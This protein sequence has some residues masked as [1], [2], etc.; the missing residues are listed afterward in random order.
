MVQGYIIFPSIIDI[1]ERLANSI[2]V[3]KD[4]TIIVDF[5][6]KGIETAQIF[7]IGVSMVS[8][9]W[10]FSEYNSVR[11][12]MLLDVTVS[13]CS[14][15]VMFMYMLFQ[16]IARL[17]AFMLFTLFWG[18]GN[19]YPLMIFITIH[20]ILAS[21]LHV[22]F[23]EDITYWHK[24]HYLKFFHNVIMNSFASIY[25]HNYLRFD[26]MPIV[27]R[28]DKKSLEFVDS[29]RPGLHIST[30]L[31]QLS[32]D[33]L[34]LVEFIIMLSFGFN[35]SVEDLVN[36][37][38]VFISVVFT[39]STLAFILRLTY[40]NILHV[41]NNVIL[42]GKKLIRQ[43]IITGDESNIQNRFFK[44]VFISRNTWILGSL[45]HIETTL[46]VLPT[47]IIDALKGRGKD[48]EENFTDVTR[49][50]RPQSIREFATL[51]SPNKLII[52]LLFFPM[53]VLVIAINMIIIALLLIGL[54]L[55]IPIALLVFLYNLKSGFRAVE[56]SDEEEGINTLELPPEI[57]RGEQTIFHSDSNLTLA[58][59]Q[60]SLVEENGI[61]N[62]SKLTDA[63]ADEFEVFAMLLLC[64]NRKKYPLKRLILDN[65]DLTDEK[66]YKLVPLIV[67][68]EKVCLNGSQKMTTD[69]WDCLL[70]ALNNSTFKLRVLEMKI[71]K[72]DDD[73]IRFRREIFLEE[74]KGSSMT[75]ES[76][77]KIALFIPKL[78]K[79]YMDDLF[80]DSMILDLIKNRSADEILEA[81]KKLASEILSEAHNRRLKLLSLQGCSI[82]DDVMNVIASAL[83]RI[84]KV[85][86]G[87]NNI[88][89]LGWQ[90][91]SNAWIDA[92]TTKDTSLTHLSL[93]IRNVQQHFNGKYL[94]DR[95]LEHLNKIILDL[96]DVDLTGQTEITTDGWNSLFK[97]LRSRVETIKKGS[98]TS[99]VESGEEVVKFNYKL[100]SINLTNCK[101]KPETKE[102]ID[103]TIKELSLDIKVHFGENITSSKFSNCFTWC[104]K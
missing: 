1:I 80:N 51:L 33:I 96:E 29:Q 27:Q 17:I 99:L 22:F 79:V 46:L 103:T 90:T 83:V 73:V 16:V 84:K 54:V 77:S 26:E 67:K 25:F 5:Q 12:N 30:L 47:R 34:Y 37:R 53:V 71:A 49:I 65:C 4:G 41:W 93:A 43:E 102:M 70:Q 36:Q 87:K 38:Y 35:S 40:Y 62:L 78:E 63:T 104:Y 56:L 28:I 69:G 76:L 88:S 52:S 13:P 7:S 14:R 59:F 11:K 81:W 8:L 94:S 2:S 32:F 19:F 72:N 101:I 85:N 95:G 39:L 89:S 100:K 64:L 6:L 97:M 92:S 55:T 82:N 24:G 20:M 10:C 74:L 42:S 45:K 31:R 15:I 9:A 68:F 58:Y 91:F 3:N 44:Y 21:I 86:L 61:I 48:L 57:D 98:Q 60:K 18:P 66:L 50:N 23:S 75:A